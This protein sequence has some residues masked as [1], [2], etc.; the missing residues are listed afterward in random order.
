MEVEKIR[1]ILIIVVSPKESILKE[2][3]GKEI[4][5]KSVEGCENLSGLTTAADGG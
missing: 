3:D 4:L 2:Q 5:T 1:R